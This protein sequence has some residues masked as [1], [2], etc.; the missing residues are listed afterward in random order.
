MWMVL[1][2]DADKV[3][4]QQRKAK[5]ASLLSGGEPHSVHL[6]LHHKPD[7]MDAFGQPKP[8]IHS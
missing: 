2:W 4:H 1:H 5:Y 6:S 8:A 7:C 3:Y